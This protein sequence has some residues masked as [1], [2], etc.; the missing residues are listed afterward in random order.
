MAPWSAYS[1]HIHILRAEALRSI[2][3][4]EAMLLARLVAIAEPMSRL[5]FE[6]C[7][8]AVCNT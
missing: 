5:R 1:S 3:P 4:D 2:K 7:L 6:D 8:R